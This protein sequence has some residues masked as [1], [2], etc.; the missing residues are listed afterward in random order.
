MKLV[1]TRRIHWAQ[2]IT[3]SL[4][5]NVSRRLRR[6]FFPLLAF[7]YKIRGGPV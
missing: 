7:R 1:R 4:P 5:G 2:E 3:A 6:R